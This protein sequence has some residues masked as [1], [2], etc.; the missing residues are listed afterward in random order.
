VVLPGIIDAHTHPAQ[1]AQDWAS[2]VSTTKRSRRGHQEPGRGMPQGSARRARSMVRSGHGQSVRTDAEPGGSR[3]D[4]GRRPLLL[5]GSDGHTVW[6]N[7]PA[8]SLAHIT[9]QPWIRPA[10]IS[11]A[12]RGPS[13]GYAA[14]HRRRD[15][16]GRQARGRADHE[17]A[18]LDKAFDSMRAVAS[19]PYRMPPSTITPCRFTN[20]CMTLIG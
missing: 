6:A 11:S 13:H 2:A 8:L 5:T 17:A 19:R 7:S 9:P 10:V 12:M 15:C 3:L 1:S 16:V 14:R 4:A 18:Q 20:V